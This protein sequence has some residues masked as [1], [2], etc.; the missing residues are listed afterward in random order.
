[1]CVWVGLS[2]FGIKHVRLLNTPYVK[3]LINNN[4]LYVL[5]MNIHQELMNYDSY[6]YIIKGIVPYYVLDRNI[7]RVRSVDVNNHA[8]EL[9]INP[10]YKDYLDCMVN[11]KISFLANVGLNKI[12]PVLYIY[13]AKNNIVEEGEAE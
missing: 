8:I 13:D 2:D 10:I 9:D 5:P 1:M 6:N 7:G 12:S 3:N 4:I 11:P